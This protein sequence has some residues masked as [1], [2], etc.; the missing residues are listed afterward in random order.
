MATAKEDET[1]IRYVSLW[2]FLTSKDKLPPPAPPKPATLVALGVLKEQSV[3]TP[4]LSSSE[5]EQLLEEAR[6]IYQQAIDLDPQ[7]LPAYF[8]LARLYDSLND[9][10]RAVQTYEAAIHKFPKEASLWFELGKCQARRQEWDACVTNMRQAVQLDPQNRH[11]IKTLG[12][13]LACT[14]RTDESVKQFMNAMN[15]A[16]AH[17]NVARVLQYLNQPEECLHHV[18]L[19]LRANPAL[20]SAHRLKASLYHQCASPD[21]ET[22]NYETMRRE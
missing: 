2:T 1:K 6:R 22:V 11:Y 5:Q 18:E 13:C 14:G 17:Y 8:H 19:A 16:E 7:H 9:H 20:E 15:E 4:G 10:T 21:M 3:E 12:F